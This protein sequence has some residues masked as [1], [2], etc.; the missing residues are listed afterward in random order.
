MSTIDIRNNSISAPTTIRFGDDDFGAAQLA[1]TGSEGI[2]IEDIDGDSTS[3]I[4]VTDI[5]NMIKALQKAKEVW[6]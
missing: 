4:D 2:C 1:Y 5:D 6:G 3:V